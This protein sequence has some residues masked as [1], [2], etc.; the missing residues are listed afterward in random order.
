[1]KRLVTFGLFGVVGGSLALIL[2]P[3]VI[4]LGLFDFF[5]GGKTM[6]PATAQPPFNAPPITQA[7]TTEYLDA[8]SVAVGAETGGGVSQVTGDLEA[9][10]AAIASGGRVFSQRYVC[11]NGQADTERCSLNHPGSHTVREDAGLGN[12]NSGGDPPV[13]VSGWTPYFGPHGLMVFNVALQTGAITT[14]YNQFLHQTMSLQPPKQCP[15][16]PGTVYVKPALEAYGRYLQNPQVSPVGFAESVRQMN[17]QYVYHDT[18]G[19]WA[20]ATWEPQHAVRTPGRAGA[21]GGTTQAPGYYVDTPQEGPLWIIVDAWGPVGRGTQQWKLP[22]YV[23]GS[24]PHCQYYP[25]HITQLVRAQEV[26]V[27]SGN[28]PTHIAQWTG[29]VTPSEVQYPLYPGGAAFVVKA[30]IH[31]DT[32]VYA[33]YLDNGQ[34]ASVPLVPSVNAFHPVG[35]GGRLPSPHDPSPLTVCAAI[36]R[37]RPFINEAAAATGTPAAIIASDMMN[38]SGGH[39]SAISSTGAIGLMQLEPGTARAMGVN[40]YNAQQNLLGGARYLAQ[41]HAEFH[42]WRLAFAAY[43]EGPGKVPQ[44]ETWAQAAS[45]LPPAVAQYAIDVYSLA[46]RISANTSCPA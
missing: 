38:E 33:N 12:I 35:T 2:I 5:T 19:A 20:D 34:T 26:W 17:H 30:R 39:E 13:H 14:L 7:L 45:H 37:W 42:S 36:T 1:M 31:R 8:L 16:P 11:T 41:L 10:I 40:P 28:G 22:Q 4:L 3:I 24:H 25:I 27:R 46:Q 23:G 6:Q 15:E 18:L 21:L 44:N 29:I 9:S 43:N 32:M